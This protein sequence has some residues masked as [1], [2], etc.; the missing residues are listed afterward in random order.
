MSQ[1]DNKFFGDDIKIDFVGDF[2]NKE[3]CI[4]GLCPGGKVP[5]E[6]NCQVS[7]QQLNSTK[8]L[9]DDLINKAAQF[10]QMENFSGMEFDKYKL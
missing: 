6:L 4:L 8:F 2:Q 3:N 9:R 1:Y 10:N 5:P 7:F